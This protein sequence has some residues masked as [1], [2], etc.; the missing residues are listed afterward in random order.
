[1]PPLIVEGLETV[2]HHR[3]TQHHAVVELLRRD[4]SVNARVLHRIGVAAIVGMALVAEPVERAAHVHLLAA[5]H[6]HDGQID[7]RAS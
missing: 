5:L 2:T 4:I 6:V 3:G 7:R 1:M